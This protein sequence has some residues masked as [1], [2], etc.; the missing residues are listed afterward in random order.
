MKIPRLALL[1]AALALLALPLLSST[2]ATEELVTVLLKNGEKHEHVSYRVVRAFNTVE[3]RS[4]ERLVRVSFSDIEAVLDAQGNN[5]APRL[6]GSRYRPTG[7]VSPGEGPV[8]SSGSIVLKSGERLDNVRYELNPARRELIIPGGA[9]PRAIP[10][11]S[12]GTVLDTEGKDITTALSEP[13]PWERGAADAPGLRESLPSVGP[14][15]PWRAAFVL[16]GGFD[17]PL[18]QY[19]EGTKGGLGFGGTLHFPV[20]HELA[21]RGTVSRLGV[22]FDS[23]FGLV[24]L[25]PGFQTISQSY[26]IDALRIQMGLAYYQQI[27]RRNAW[28]GFWSVHSSIGAIRHALKGTATIRNTGTGENRTVSASDTDTKLAMTSGAGATF[29]VS[30]R[31][32][33]NVSGDIDFVWTKVFRTDGSTGT[34]IKGYVLGLRGGLAFVL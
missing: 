4:G 22:G 3:L 21:L 9:Q 18:G 34:A 29:M 14:P 6:L 1:L 33:L 15:R 12:V 13:P 11:D 26:S 27:E 7:A 23:G 2:A 25:D 19:Y 31:I 10:Y 16:D 30:P 20:T 17:A 5:I 32:G 24:S 8:R 28:S